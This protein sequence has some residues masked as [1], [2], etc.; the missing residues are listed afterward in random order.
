M[1]LN[2]DLLRDALDRKGLTQDQVSAALK[3]SRQTVNK[4]VNGGDV[5]PSTG[6]AM[7]DFLG[8]D[9][10]KVVVPRCKYEENDDAA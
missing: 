2:V 6:R 7:C 1:K 5:R 8:L 4:A 9:L 3:M 10:A